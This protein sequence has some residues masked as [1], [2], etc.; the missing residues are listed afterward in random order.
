MIRVDYYAI[1]VR[2]FHV[3]RV[4]PGGWA[5]AISQDKGFEDCTVRFDQDLF[6]EIAMS[7]L[8][9]HRFV[10][11]WRDFGL[12]PHRKRTWFEICVVDRFTGPTLP[13]GWLDW[14]YTKHTVRLE[15]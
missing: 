13:C 3:E 15:S 5:T 4:Y 7:P 12:V 10:L 14:N 6:V 9:V 8:Q 2:K 11:R 1:I